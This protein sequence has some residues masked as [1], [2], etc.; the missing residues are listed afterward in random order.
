MPAAQMS[1]QEL[2]WSHV[3]KDGP[4]G[5]WLWTLKPHWT[6]YGKFKA[7]GKRQVL[8]HRYAYELLVGPIPAG[9]TLDHL[10][11]TPLCLNPDHLEP[12]TM[13][14]N[15]RRGTSPSAQNARRT[16]CKRGHPLSG[17]NLHI[18]PSDGGRVC[19]SCS[20][21]N[22]RRWRAANPEKVREYERRR[23]RVAPSA[24]ERSSQ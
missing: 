20:R 21:E 6:G 3:D 11:R 4:N 15:I 19:L 24:P 12:V 22:Q 1:E 7:R 10:C 8:P 14:E 9:L 13:A 16:H 5:C 23:V 17:E 18:R 2:F